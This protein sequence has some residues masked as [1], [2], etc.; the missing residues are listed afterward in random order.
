MSHF[1]DVPSGDTLCRDTM[2]SS[3]LT[4]VFLFPVYCKRYTIFICF[5]AGA[6]VW[7]VGDG[8]YYR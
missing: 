6:F 3:V 2:S 8:D 5:N 7:G 1:N 4:I